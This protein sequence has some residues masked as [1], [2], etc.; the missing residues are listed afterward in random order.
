MPHQLRLEKLTLG[1]VPRVDDDGTGLTSLHEIR[2][3]DFA[4]L[5]AGSLAGGLIYGAR[6]WPGKAH[7]RLTAQMLVLGGMFALLSTAGTEL[8][9]AAL[10]VAT[11]LLFAPTAV[12][13]S[14]LLDTVAPKGTVTEAFAAMVMGIV[15]GNA[16]G[17]AIGGTLIDATSYETSTLIAGAIAAAGSALALARRSTLSARE[18]QPL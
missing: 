7:A 5:S 2:S 17:N 18:P 3:H 10:L 4:A 1:D 16:L 11:G 8:T 13:G 15:A 6:T 14:T 9:L 12:L